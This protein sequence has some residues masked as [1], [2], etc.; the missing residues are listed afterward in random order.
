VIVALDATTVT[1]YRDFNLDYRSVS[2]SADR[3][4][5]ILEAGTIGAQPPFTETIGQA[6]MKMQAI[7]TISLMLNRSDCYHGVPPKTF[8]KLGF[9][10]GVK[11]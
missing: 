11:V 2:G 6:V 4:P 1:R 5:T 3:W 7:E 8:K 10:R 9:W